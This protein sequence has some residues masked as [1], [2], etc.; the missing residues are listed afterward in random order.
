MPSLNAWLLLAIVSAPVGAWSISTADSPFMSEFSHREATANLS[1]LRADRDILMAQRPVADNTYFFTLNLPGRR[2][3][4][5]DRLS[6]SF[7]HVN[8]G[9]SVA[10][11][12]L[13][14]EKTQAFSGVARAPRQAIGVKSAWVDET[15]TLWLTLSSPVSSGTTLTIALEAQN[16]LPR[17]AV[18]YGVAAYPSNRPSVAVFVDEGTL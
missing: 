11:I 5:F 12:P 1:R 7:T 10:V 2:R 4:Q 8:R 17:G 14:L 3:Q 16:R 18:R 13:N 15:G 9:N 6:F